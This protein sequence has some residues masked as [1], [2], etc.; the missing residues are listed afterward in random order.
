[1]SG[2]RRMK[3]DSYLLSSRKHMFKCIKDFN[4]RP[5]KVNLIK[6]ILGN[7]LHIIG[8]GYNFLNRTHLAQEL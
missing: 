7:S 2:G 5:D 4:V 1:M 8:T 3:V 6:Q